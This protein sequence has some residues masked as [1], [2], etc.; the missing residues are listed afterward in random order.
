MVPC[1][2]P[3]DRATWVHSRIPSNSDISLR[4]CAGPCVPMPVLL[5]FPRPA[6]T[7]KS[8]TRSHLQH[9]CK[10]DMRLWHFMAPCKHQ[11]SRQR[12]RCRQAD[13]DDTGP[14]NQC[15]RPQCMP[16]QQL[17]QQHGRLEA[18]NPPTGTPW[19]IAPC[20]R[21]WL[22]WSRIEHLISQ[23]SL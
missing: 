20:F 22:V 18:A 5:A 21:F 8:A 23:S 11:E 9:L 15:L 14:L 10:A 16:W 3:S 17:D 12:G 2:R 4:I 19:H 13:Q 7:P 6:M 1:V